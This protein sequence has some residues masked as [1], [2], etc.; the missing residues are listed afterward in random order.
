MKKMIYFMLLFSL[1]GCSSGGGSD[2]D[3]GMEPPVLSSIQITSSNGN[4]LDLFDAATVTL[5]VSGR[6]QFGQPIAIS[7]TVMWSARRE[8]SRCPD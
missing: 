6:D 4:N 8:R 3:N 5:T 2:D 7:G 1:M